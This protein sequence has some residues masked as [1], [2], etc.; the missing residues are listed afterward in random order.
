MVEKSEKPLRAAQ[1]D[2]RHF[3][4]GGLFYGLFGWYD[5][6]CFSS[7]HDCTKFVHYRCSGHR[8]AGLGED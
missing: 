6:G 4:S 2:T 1:N 7:P 3:T 8:L 5:L